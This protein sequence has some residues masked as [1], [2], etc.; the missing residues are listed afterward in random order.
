MSRSTTP[1][2]ALISDDGFHRYR[3]WRTLRPQLGVDRDRQVLWVMLNPSTADSD[4]DDATIRRCRGFTARWGA[5][6]FE[7][8]NLFGLRATDPDELIR[9]NLEGRDPEGDENTAHVLDA[10]REQVPDRGDRVLLAWGAHPAALLS[11]LPDLF[12]LAA[13]DGTGPALECL[14]YTEDGSPR[15]PLYVPRLQDPLPWPRPV[16][17]DA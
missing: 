11:P 4:Q 15:H 14:G 12:R 8:V 5:G 2:G 13:A 9:A 6:R 7:V 1:D 3:L 16:E 10:I 17:P